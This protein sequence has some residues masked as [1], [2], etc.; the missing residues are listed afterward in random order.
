[1]RIDD[2][3]NFTGKAPKGQVFATGNKVKE[4][5]SAEGAGDMSR[6]EQTS[7]DI[8]DVQMSAKAKVKSHG[9]KPGYR[10]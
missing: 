10:N 8:K 7:E 4:Y 9:L 2:H 1:M 5:T 3:A 6:Y